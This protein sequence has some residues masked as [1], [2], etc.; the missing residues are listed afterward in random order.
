[1]YMLVRATKYS[2]AIYFVL[3]FLELV[4]PVPESLQAGKV[5][6]LI[7]VTNFNHA[8]THTHTHTYTRARSRMLIIF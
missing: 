2:L 3:V 4:F 1:M 6:G 8:R 5:S 7:D